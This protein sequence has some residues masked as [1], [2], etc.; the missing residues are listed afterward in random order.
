MKFKDC[1]IGLVIALIGGANAG[2]SFSFISNKLLAGASAGVG[3]LVVG[4]VLLRFSL[5][6]PK[7]Y[8]WV[9][10]YTSLIHLLAIS[11]PMLVVRWMNIEAHFSQLFVWG[12]PGYEFHAYSMEFYKVLLAGLMVDGIRAWRCRHKNKKPETVSVPGS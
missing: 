7:P 11:L 5:K 10:F 12:I 1:I 9:T 3:F 2:L 4:G 6:A 8:L